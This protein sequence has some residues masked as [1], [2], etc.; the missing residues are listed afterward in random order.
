MTTATLAF[1]WK[2]P[3]PQVFTRAS[4]PTFWPGDRR[5]RPLDLA[6]RRKRDL[7]FLIEALPP[8]LEGIIGKRF[9]PTRSVVHWETPPA[10]PISVR[11]GYTSDERTAFTKLGI[12]PQITVIA[13][14]IERLLDAPEGEVGGLTHNYLLAIQMLRLRQLWEEVNCRAW[15]EPPLVVFTRALG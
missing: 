13:G 10:L 11:Q 3:V 1:N 8:A 6:K 9:D 15:A 5:C 4:G 14:M 7:T 12:C 2:A